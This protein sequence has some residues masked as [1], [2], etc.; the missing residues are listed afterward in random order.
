MH[1]E[2][3]AL[4]RSTRLLNKAGIDIT[5]CLL[6]LLV[7]A[8]ALDSMAVGF[9]QLFSGADRAGKAP[10]AAGKTLLTR[11]QAAA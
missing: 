8:L 6:G 10:G 7:A 4:G 11:P 5:A 3:V 1:L 2:F 9:A